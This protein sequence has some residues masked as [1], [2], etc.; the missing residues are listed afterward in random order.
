MSPA[1]DFC[2][3]SLALPPSEH[4]DFGA[5]LVAAC[6]DR[7]IGLV[8]PT[9]DGELQ[10]LARIKEDLAANGV[11]L[12]VSGTET[13]RNCLDKRAFADFCR[14]RGYPIPP[15]ADKGASVECPLFARPRTGAGARGARR[16][17]GPVGAARLLKDNRWV[18]QEWIE[19]PE[20]TIDVISDLTGTALQGVA[21]RRVVVRGG[22]SQISRV[23]H[24]PV[25]VDLAMK[26]CD[27]LGCVGPSL[28]QAFLCPTRGPL[29][30]EV[31]ARLG[32]AS[33]LS[34]KAGLETP[35]RLFQLAQ[36]EAAE[37]A[38]P[39]E[40]AVGLTLRRYG[41]DLIGLTDER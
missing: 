22:E 5:A 40:I 30:I 29:L 34:I 38:A 9:R 24:Q 8:I 11:T 15:L 35:R 17:E 3:G 12:V 10:T 14:R 32:G 6:Q 25:L 1:L 18:V 39:R 20:Y 23:E 2:D 4:E 27:E 26:L 28:V 19:A 16:V 21:R 31:N 7:G 13:L 33:I 37:A 41:A 36:G